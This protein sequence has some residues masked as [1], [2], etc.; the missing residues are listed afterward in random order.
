MMFRFKL[1]KKQ[2][3]M[4]MA[5]GVLLFLG[6]MYRSYPFFQE[7]VSP[8]SE[9]ELK[10]QRVIKCQ[11]RLKADQGLE[12]SAKHLKGALNKAEEGLL[13]EERPS[14][15]AVQIQEILKKITDQSGAVIRRLQVLKPEELKP[16]GYLSVP[17]E[18]YMYATISQ[19]KDVLYRIGVFQKYLTVKKLRIDYTRNQTGGSIRCHVTVAGYMKKAKG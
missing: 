1:D 18:F 4:L 7:L 10:E 3:Y 12:T 17:V 8:G 13:T 14:L 6:L 11:K 2:K 15:A 19:F 5:G 9:I 16:D